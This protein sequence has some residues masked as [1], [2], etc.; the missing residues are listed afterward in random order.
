MAR[1]AD[2]DAHFDEK[3]GKLIITASNTGRADLADA[4]REGGYQA[5]QSHIAECFHEAYEP[6]DAGDVP[7][8]LTSAPMWVDADD[9]ARPDNG[10]TIL[11]HGARVFY[12]ANYCFE[13]EWDTLRNCGR[14]ELDLVPSDPDYT[15]P[16]MYPDDF[17]DFLPGG[18]RRGQWFWIGGANTDDRADLPEPLRSLF[19]AS[20]NDGRDLIDPGQYFV[21][22]AGVLK[23]PYP[24]T[25]PGVDHAKQA[26]MIEAP[27]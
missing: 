21:N 8:C 15:P 3:R 26:G 9:I 22:A 11:L 17:A 18:A 4:I 23:G 24:P 6:I 5:A 12:F 20:I 1:K 14:V 7:G 25:W 16:P 2:I 13:S 27:R 19:V 10:E